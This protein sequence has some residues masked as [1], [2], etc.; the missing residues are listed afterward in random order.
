[1][2]RVAAPRAGDDASQQIEWFNN[3]AVLESWDM[4]AGRLL[5]ELGG[6]RRHLG[7]V[8]VNYYWTNQ[9][10]W[11]APETPLHADD[12]RRCSLADL[13]DA[14]WRR[15]GGDIL[16]TET[17]HIGEHRASWITALGRTA[18]DLIL[19]GV[20]LRGICLYPVLGMPSWHRPADWL[21]MGLWDVDPGSSFD[22]SACTPAIRALREAEELVSRTLAERRAIEGAS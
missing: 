19:R 21:P 8:G 18:V 4:L 13:V 9:W 14:V 5:P 12:E 16:I 6:S 1:V 3:V 7:I 22:R 10:E 11:G 17:A 20:P 2:C 15:Y